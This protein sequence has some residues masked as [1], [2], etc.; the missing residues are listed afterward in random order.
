[1]LALKKEVG[2][3]Q[4]KEAPRSQGLLFA[5]T[6]KSTDQRLSKTN[7]TVTD[8]KTTQLRPPTASQAMP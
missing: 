4:P 5:R 1:M 2:A 3:M 7:I 8:K 6:R